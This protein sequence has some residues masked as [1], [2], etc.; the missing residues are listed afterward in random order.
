MEDKEKQIEEMAK[1]IELAIDNA[2]K[3]GWYIEKDLPIWIAE[4]IS[5]K[6]QPKLPKDSFVLTN[7]NAEELA[8]LMVTSPQ[9]QSVMSDLIKAWQKETVEKCINIIE[10]HYKKCRLSIDCWIVSFAETEAAKKVIKV[11][12]ENTKKDIAKQFSVEIKG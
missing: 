6:Y 3:D 5:E 11:F 1:D 8:N 12:F 7:D 10:E 4:Q 2:K 9:M